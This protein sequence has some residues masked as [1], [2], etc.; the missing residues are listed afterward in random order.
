VN[1]GEIPNT[2][3]AYQKSGPKEPFQTYTI[4]THRLLG[5]NK[6]VTK[7]VASILVNNTYISRILWAT[8][9]ALSQPKYFFLSVFGKKLR[10]VKPSF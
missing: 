3:H 4:V 7:G 8:I 9:Q 5:L 2:L 1:S 6:R 10:C